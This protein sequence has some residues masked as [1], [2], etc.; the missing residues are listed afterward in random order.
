MKLTFYGGAMS[1]AGANYLLEHDGVKILV[2][3][4]LF[5]GFKYAEILNY[6]K[7]SYDP[8][9][10]DYVFITH[11]HNDHIG[12]LPKLY[13]EGFR[14]KIYVVEPTKELM[15]RAF[16]DNW[17]HMAEEAKSDGHDPLYMQDDIEG[18]MGLVE[19]ISYHQKIELNPQGSTFLKIQGRTSNLASQ[20][21][22]LSATFFNSGHILGSAIVCFKYWSEEAQGDSF[23]SL[24][25]KKLRPPEPL[26]IITSKI[27]FTGDLGNSPSLLLPD[28]EFVH[29][30]DYAVIESA[31]GSRQHEVRAERAVVLKEVV[32]YVVKNKGALMIPS[33][34]I[35]RTQEI[36]FELHQFFADETMPMV[37]VFLDSP[38]AN[39]MTEVYNR[40]SSYLN[41][42]VRSHLGEKGAP[43]IFPSVRQ[44]KT[45]ERPRST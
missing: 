10:V 41:S 5:Q 8:A 11:S 21:T 28:K 1:G 24:A 19:G 3:C 7:F 40:F 4:G 29:D 25:E 26:E 22:N 18:V 9:E 17:S 13:K 2:D 35:E 44:T 37:P 15:L 6:E 30:A 12:R 16:P 34:A 23:F 33:F 14:G 32:E 38:L 42:E 27:Y 45:T 43:F 20:G 39:K 31:Y 36:L